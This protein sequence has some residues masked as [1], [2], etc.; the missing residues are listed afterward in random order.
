[1]TDSGALKNL[2]GRSSTRLRLTMSL[3]GLLCLACA[4]GVLLDS[5][6]WNAGLG[7]QIGGVAGVAFFLCAGA[8]LLWGAIRGQ[9]HHARRLHQ[10]LLTEPQRISSAKL[11]VARAVPNASWSSDDGSARRGLHVAI[12]TDTGAYWVLPVSRE[13]SLTAMT[14]LARL[15]PSAIIEPWPLSG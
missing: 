7:W 10:I 12:T 3:S 5:E 15:C 9:S 2:I 13:E 11:V 4:A 8:V 6:M 1:M 14:E